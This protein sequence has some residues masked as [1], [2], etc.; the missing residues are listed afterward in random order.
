MP[1]PR[2]QT[3]VAFRETARRRAREAAHLLEIEAA[4]PARAAYDAAVTCA[5]LAAEC[6]LKAALLHGHQC[7]SVAD[8][9]DH[10][11]QPSFA[12]RSGHQLRLLLDRQAPEVI[13]VVPPPHNEI[14]RLGGCDRYAYRYGVRKPKRVD[15]EPFVVAARVVVAWMEH[16]VA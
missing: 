7:D 10:P 13:R 3:A 1:T 6:A 9:S 4:K 12:G 15:A 8:Y 11:D 16:V 2:E 5:L 14:D